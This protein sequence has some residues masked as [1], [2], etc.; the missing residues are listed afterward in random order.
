MITIVV[1]SLLG[2]IAHFVC[3]RMDWPSPPIWLDGPIMGVLRETLGGGSNPD[4]IAW[5]TTTGITLAASTA[6]MA[7]FLLHLSAGRMFKTPS[8]NPS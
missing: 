1:I 7:V 2:P 8:P 6:W 4:A 3:A 5:R